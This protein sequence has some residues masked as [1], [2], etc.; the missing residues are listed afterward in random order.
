MAEQ[1]GAAGIILF[2]DPADYTGGDTNQVYPND[3]WLPPSGAQRGVIRFGDGDPETPG[4]PSIGNH[5][6]QRTRLSY[7][8]H[9]R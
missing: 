6:V 3:W 9:M 7:L 5:L 1:H 4:Y 8:F 2:S